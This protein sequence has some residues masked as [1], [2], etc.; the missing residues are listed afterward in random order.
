MKLTSIGQKV[1]LFVFVLLLAVGLILGSVSYITSTN[2]VTQEVEYGMNMLAGESAEMVDSLVR[3]ELAVL[4]TLAERSEIRSM[5][6]DQ[7]Q[8]VLLQE[9]ERLEVAD[10]GIGVVYPD[11]TALFADGDQVSLRGEEYV[12]QAFE[13]QSAVSDPVHSEIEDQ[14]EMMF[15]VPIG[16]N[17]GVLLA[18]ADGFYLTEMLAD[19][20]FG[21]SGY[22]FMINNDGNTIAHPDEQHVINATNMM[23]E[24][25]DSP[26]LRELAA[27]FEKM[28]DRQTGVDH[29]YFDGVDRIMAYTPVE[30]TSW[31]LAVG[32]YEDEVLAGVFGLRNILIILTSGLIVVG[33][34]GAFLIGRKI[35]IPI[36]VVSSFA[37]KMA[38]GDFSFALDNSV[39][40]RRDEV[41]SLA[42]SFRAMQD[43]LREMFSVVKESADKVNSSGET[44]ASSSEEMN[45]SLEEVSASANEFSSSAQELNESA[46]EMQR[47]GDQIS[48]KAQNSSESVDSAVNQMQEI[49]NSVS[50]LKSDF[51]TLNEQAE[52]IS[53][54]VDAIKEIA[55]QTNMLALN[56]AIEAA[57]AGE[58]GKGFAVVADEVRKLAEQSSNSAEEI[59]GIV[60]GIQTQSK[61]VAEKMEESVETV[62]SGRQAVSSTGKNLHSIID[63]IQKLVD[64]I[65]QVSSSAQEISSGSQEVSAAVE[66]Q[67]ATMNDIANSA[68]ELQTLVND[69]N[70]AV[71]KFSF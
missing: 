10:L 68:T 11:R 3:S 58:Y 6:W 20:G 66:E 36:K 24:A 4:E 14:M 61:N 38:A 67:T 9:R 71:N 39:L 18:R 17:E 22:S 62:E 33:L 46:E 8:P 40:G 25:E 55:E 42:Q 45:A 54:I 2:V 27:V 7:Q 28:A 64:T 56:A 31:S 43:S 30:G 13:G 63:E 70:E 15:A 29:Y 16:N 5:D 41:G 47:L 35:A 32:S 69:L 52:N 37:D 65:A 12:E 49:S 51:S 23:E 21:E 34:T 1:V 26:E 44:L 59:I 60:E 19:K 53:K 57:R 50:T 48:E